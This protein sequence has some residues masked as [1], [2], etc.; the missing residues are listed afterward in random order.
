[1]LEAKP[2]NYFG[3]ARHEML[4]FVPA[5]AQAIL[6][7]GCSGGEFG[8]IVKARQPVE[9]WGIEPMAEPAAAAEDKL[10]RVLRGDIERDD[11]SLPTDYFDC[12][13]LNDVLEHLVDP[14]TVL[15]RLKC[16]LKPC[17][18][19]IASIPNMRHHDVIKELLL[20][21][22]WQYV[23]AG[24]LDRTHLRFFT[25]TS[26][27]RMFRDCGYEVIRAE[28]I[29]GTK[30]PWQLRLVNTVLRGALDDMQFIQFACVARKPG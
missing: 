9:Y 26:A 22:D 24:V 12:L 10:D 19:V 11:I 17:G 20:E 30:A 5:G 14:W 3:Y 18:A 21:A 15:R 8:K 2:G 28:G 6:E 13:V 27:I 7:V 16:S 29:N 4:P 23:D 25:K 1:M